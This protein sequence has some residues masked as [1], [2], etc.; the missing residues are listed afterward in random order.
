[1]AD[2]AA[3]KA[4]LGGELE[5]V[6]GH[7]VSFVST[8]RNLAR[9]PPVPLGLSARLRFVPL[10]L[11]AVD[12]LPEGAECTA[13]V[14]PGKGGLLKKAV[15]GLAGPFAA[16]LAGV[17]KPDW[18]VHD[19]CYHWIPPIADEHKPPK[20]VIYVALG[21]ETPST[22]KNLQELALGL[23]LA[24]V[25]FMWALRESVGMSDARTSIDGHSVLPNG[26][27]QRTQEW[28]LVCMG[29][30]PQVKVLA[31]EAVGAFLTHCGWGSTLESFMF[32]HPLV[33]LLFVVDQPIV[34]RMMVEKGIGV[35]IGRDE[36]D[37]SFDRNGVATAVRH[38]MVDDKRN[39][40][41]S[42]AKKLQEILA[43]QGQQEKYI[44]DLVEHLR[45]YRDNGC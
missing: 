31:H 44:D 11:P 7:A 24:G 36:K 27:E 22:I 29:W 45:L 2:L 19:F 13:D 3:T 37:G 8:P 35:E 1:M 23:E 42:N 9:L 17:R 30:I 20:F 6:M 39:V 34:A 10:P 21:S 5:V 14:P 32:G 26:F 41:M 4:A 18:I 12:G 15:D 40:F 33:M 25:H 43:D 28:G 16:F 38:V